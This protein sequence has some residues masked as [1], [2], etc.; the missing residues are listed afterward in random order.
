MFTR[1]GSTAFVAGRRP[2]RSIF[3]A[4]LDVQIRES[5]TKLDECR[6]Q[7][8]ALQGELQQADLAH[9]M[10]KAKDATAAR[11]QTAKEAQLRQID[12][13]IAV[14]SAQAAPQQSAE[15]SGREEELKELEQ[16]AAELQQNIEKLIKEEASLTEQLQEA[17]SSDE[18]RQLEKAVEEKKV[19]LTEAEKQNAECEVRLNVRAQRIAKLEAKRTHAQRCLE[20]AARREQSAEKQLRMLMEHAEEARRQASLV[21]P[22]ELETEKTPELLD[23]EILSLQQRLKTE[24]ANRPTIV[25]AQLAYNRARDRMQ[26]S[27]QNCG[28]LSDLSKKMGAQLDRR[29]KRWYT[30]LHSIAQR[31]SVLFNSFL[32]QQGCSG[33][34][35]FDH[36]GQSMVIEVQL[37][38]IRTLEEQCHHEFLMLKQ[39]QQHKRKQSGTGSKQASPASSGSGDEMLPGEGGARVASDSKTL[40]GGERSFSTVAFLLA[41][42]EAMEAPF[43]AMD[44][45]DVFM[46]AVNRQIS[47]HTLLESTQLHKN[48]QFIFITPHDLGMLKNTTDVKI[49]KLARP[50]RSAPSTPQPVGRAST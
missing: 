13:E 3:G 38:G 21:F 31:T 39:L 12:R 11:E 48:R 45:F 19:Q 7:T 49:L 27:Q 23:R 22:T 40:S 9:K 46:D 35:Q 30:F 42:W 47:I 36:I 25:Q 44:E 18:V 50:Q 28:Q 37:D 16:S 34:V 2:R 24:R 20:D 32:S 17:Q 26:Q 6:A 5:Q 33:A 4:N 41:L 1:N 43:R 10:A 15:E 14:L 29:G 8:R